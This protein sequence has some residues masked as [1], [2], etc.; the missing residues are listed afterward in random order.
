MKNRIIKF[1]KSVIVFLMFII[2]F[3]A[4]FTIFSFIR[5]NLKGGEDSQEVFKEN[6]EFLFLLAGVDST[7]EEYGTRTDTLMLVRLDEDDKKVD[8]ISIPRDSYVSINGSMDKINAAHSYGGIDL[9]METVREL[10]GINL[11]KYLVISFDAVIAGIDA[12]G[13]MEV[14]IPQEVASAM[15]REPGVHKLSGEEVLGYVRFRKGYQN[16]DLG[17]ISTQQDFLKQF[18][19][20][21]S[22]PSNIP[23]L[24]SVYAAMKPHMKTNIS[25]PNLASLGLSFRNMSA[26]DID[27][28]R[29]EGEPIDIGGVSYFSLYDESIANIR[30]NYLKSFLRN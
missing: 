25:F 29:I 4:G 27:T 10:F 14:D 24:P 8:L 19:K 18:I 6:N 21:M 12:L 2:V 13:G 7:G 23:K 3:A 26:D 1:I 28:V 20:E 15:G 5:F 30:E 16:A 17:R 11:D 22:K 9:T